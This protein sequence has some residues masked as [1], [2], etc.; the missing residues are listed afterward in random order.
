MASLLTL[1]TFDLFHPGHVA[2][3]RQC[4]ELSADVVVA[5]NPD[6]FVAEFKGQ[7][8]VLSAQER[9]Q[10]VAS[11]KYVSRA[12]IGGGRDSTN[13][14]E[15]WLR[16]ADRERPRLLAIGA[17]WAGRDYL[18]QLGIDAE[19]LRAHGITLV[20]V[21]PSNTL[22]SAEIRERCQQLR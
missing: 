21:H 19:F 6:E 12:I 20:Y 18:G 13:V 11:C 7:L 15:S 4:A 2:F 17:D 16:T 1:G 9:M 22:H 8:P 3:L 14:I 5:V 10:V